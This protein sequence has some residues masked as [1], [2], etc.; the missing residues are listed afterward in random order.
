[1][2][3]KINPSVLDDLDDIYNYIKLDNPQKAVEVRD[4]ILKDIYKIPK[5]PFIGK[6][7]KNIIDTEIDFRYI[8]TYSYASIYR[9]EEDCVIVTRVV[10]TRRNFNIINFN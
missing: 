10:H 6:Y 1:M 4:N 3:L 2:N 9:V 5:N 7:L 8:I